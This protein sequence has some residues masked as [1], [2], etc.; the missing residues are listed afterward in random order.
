MRLKIEL[1]SRRTEETEETEE[2]EEPADAVTRIPAGYRFIYYGRK[3]HS[4]FNTS[5]YDRAIADNTSLFLLWSDENG[6]P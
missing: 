6:E 4:F 5:A 3:I 2:P 1:K